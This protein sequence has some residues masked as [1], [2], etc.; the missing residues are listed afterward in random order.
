MFKMIRKYWFVFLT[1]FMV[2]I[3]FIIALI[4]QIYSLSQGYL[5]RDFSDNVG[6][7]NYCY[8]S[9][10]HKIMQCETKDGHKIMVQEYWIK[11]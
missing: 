1:G 10:N 11:N 7:A 5:Y 4:I 9:Y 8:Q 2:I 6:E 3:A